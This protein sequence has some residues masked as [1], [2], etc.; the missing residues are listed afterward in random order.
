MAELGGPSIVLDLVRTRLKYAR[1][2]SIPAAPAKPD[3][4]DKGTQTASK[5]LQLLL[6]LSSNEYLAV[7]MGEVSMFRHTA[8]RPT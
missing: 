2:R 5:A 1:Q 6:N 7:R 4:D 8:A 3:P